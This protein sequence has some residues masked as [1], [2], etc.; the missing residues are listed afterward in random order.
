MIL[1]PPPKPLLIGMPYISVPFITPRSTRSLHPQTHTFHFLL[2]KV[3]GP[4]TSSLETTWDF[5]RNVKAQSV[6]LPCRSRLHFSRFPGSLRNTVDLPRVGTREYRNLSGLCSKQHE[7]LL[8]TEKT[9]RSIF[10]SNGCLTH[11]FSLKETN[12]EGLIR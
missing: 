5:V 10:L 12:S 8:D 3:F 11:S 7:A 4:K 6:P 2:S 9:S 1:S